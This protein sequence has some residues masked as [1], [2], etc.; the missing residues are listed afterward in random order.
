MSPDEWFGLLAGVLVVAA[1]LLFLL[2]L[3]NSA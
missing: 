2:L 3:R 1:F